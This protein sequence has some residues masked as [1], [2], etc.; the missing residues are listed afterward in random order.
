MP[1]AFLREHKAE[2]AVFAAAAAVFA[3][4]L[5]FGYV[6]DDFN[7]VV[8]N[9][10]L[11]RW[12]RLG[13][14]LL[15]GYWQPW[16]GASAT[17]SI[18]RPVVAL[19]F[20]LQAQTLDAPWAFHAANVLLHAGVSALLASTLRRWLA[21]GAALLA[22]LLFAVHPAN[23]EAVAR[24][25]SRPYLLCALFLLCAWRGLED[26]R[27]RA[28]CLWYALALGSLET[29]ALFPAAFAL[30][31]HWRRGPL[32]LRAEARAQAALWGVLAAYFAL[33]AVLLPG[34]LIQGGTPYFGAVG[35]WVKLL[36]LARF[37]TACYLLPLVTGTGVVLDAMRPFFPDAAPG[38]PVAMLL[39]AGW[40]AFFAA[41]ARAAWRR[42]AWGFWTLWAGL[43]ILPNSH[44]LFRYD[45][46]GAA[47]FL[48]LP[49]LGLCALAAPT[50]LRPGRAP[51]L[52]AAA[53]VLWF[54]GRTLAVAG[55]YRDSR[56]YWTAVLAQ[57]PR[58]SAAFDSI[59]VAQAEEGDLAGA[60]ASFTRSI[61]ADPTRPE[62]YYNLARLRMD[63]GRLA[64][65]E[66]LLAKAS[67]ANPK[68]PDTLVLRALAAE[69]LGRPADAERLYAEALAVKPWDAAAR[70]N[71]GRLLWA[72]GERAAAAEHWRA[73]LAEH[74]GD[75]DAPGL[76]ALLA[77]R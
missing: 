76:R 9:P 71:L 58:S 52:A 57:N 4:S 10:F 6:Q 34:A 51:A 16:A 56:T 25:T 54:A 15:S 41:A 64:E 46:L 19:S 36:T 17:V 63:G 39:L 40:A 30:F 21:P 13:E 44:L 59:G 45:T 68:D 31:V 18:Y 29:A 7:L 1:A 70:F 3:P 47:R 65:A 20:F 38:D 42:E 73:F 22:A 26:G 60:E 77:A 53:A 32:A 61:A 27:A 49:S 62:A 2:L 37:W 24:V 69:G 28:A 14:L 75:P 72:R 33:R 5:F 43:F 74:P 66:E 67:L 50:A 35:A 55:A 8:H 11:R 23:A 48:Y 12:D